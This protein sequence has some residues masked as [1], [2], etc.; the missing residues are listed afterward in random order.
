MLLRWWWVVARHTADGLNPDDLDPLVYRG[1]DR[2]A[3]FA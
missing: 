1:A 2:R 3:L